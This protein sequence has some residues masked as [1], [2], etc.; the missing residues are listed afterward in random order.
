MEGPRAPAEQEFPQ[1][2]HFLD[3]NLRGKEGWSIAAEYPLALT[4]SNIHNMR[5]ITEADQV[6]SHAV[7]RPIITK[8]PFGLFKVGAIGSVVTSSQHRN[9]GLSQKIL[10]DCLQ[11]AEDQLCDF[12]ILWTSLY[13]FYRK[14]GFELAGS[15]IS[16]RIE[17]ELTVAGPPLRMIETNQVSA[18]AIHRLFMQHTVCSVRTIDDIQ[19][20]LQIPNARI[21][22]AWDDRNRLQAYAVEGKG[23]D[24]KGYIHEWGG[25]VSKLL[26]LFAHI[27]KTQG[28][29]I[30]VIVPAHS[31]GLLR[32]F[33]EH[34]LAPHSGYLG[35]IKLLHPQLLFN[36]IKRHARAIGISDLQ[37][38]HQNGVF[39]F[40]A[41]DSSYSTESENEMVRLLFGPNQASDLV[42]GLDAHTRD[43]LERLLPIPMW[44][45]GWDSI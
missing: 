31:H 16:V 28:Q 22:T 25:G 4:H 20:Y 15:E 42:A 12:A 8:T 39:Y 5:I 24:L 21:Y 40:G 13:D 45:W 36:K 23:V 3:Q 29:S 38:E 41:G 14:L 19:K 17:K 44:V 9:R 7:V 32:A 30:T 43:V 10:H 6:L 11:A 27:R 33:N 18:E 1:I 37:L 35:M 26:P 2:L 34:D